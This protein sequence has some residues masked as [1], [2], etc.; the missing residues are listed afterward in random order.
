M[1]VANIININIIIIIMVRVNGCIG[2][3]YSLSII[4]PDIA[5]C[6]TATPAESVY[7]VGKDKSP[8]SSC[9]PVQQQPLDPGRYD[10]DRYAHDEI[11]E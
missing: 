3:R 5:V 9:H 10:S 1:C 11:G 8:I 7:V 4:L 6:V 2:L